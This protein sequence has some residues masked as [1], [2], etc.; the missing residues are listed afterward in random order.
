[1]R[2]SP[3]TWVVL[4][5]REPVKGLNYLAFVGNGLST[6]NISANKIDTHLLV[7]GGTWW[8]P[9]GPTVRVNTELFRIDGAPYPV[10][11]TPYTAGMRGWVPMI[12]TVLAFLTIV[13]F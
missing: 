4:G 11:L 3:I 2:R 1:M 9:L 6:L 13:G 10:A 5:E 7:S 8:E 12:Q